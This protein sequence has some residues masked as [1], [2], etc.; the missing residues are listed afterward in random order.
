MTTGDP[1]NYFMAHLQYV[2]EYEEYADDIRE[3]VASS[4]T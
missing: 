1:K 2:L 3:F 4:S